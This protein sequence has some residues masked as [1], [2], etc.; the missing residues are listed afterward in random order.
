MAVYDHAVFGA[1]PAVTRNRFG[2]GVLTYE[3]TVLSDALQDRVV[4]DCL[5]AASVV[6]ADAGLPAGVKAKH[7]LLADGAAVHAYLNFSS[8]RR[9]FVY[10]REPGRDML[11]GADVV[12]GARVAL[13]PWDLV[14]VRGG[15]RAGHHRRI[16]LTA[17]PP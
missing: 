2:R 3:G 7:G 1:F 14:I 11:T 17:P 12:P 15:R 5:A 13:A 4:A 10:G 8:G 9:E 16:R 6:V